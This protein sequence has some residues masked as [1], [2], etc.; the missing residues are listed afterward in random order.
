VAFLLAEIPSQLISKKLGPDRWIPSESILVNSQ[1]L[2]HPDMS[3][4]S[5]NGCLVD[6]RSISSRSLWKGFFLYMQSF[7][8]RARRWLH[9]R[10]SVVVRFPSR[11]GVTMAAM[12]SLT[13]NPQALVFLHQRRATHSPL[14]LLDCFGWDPDID[15]YHG[16][17]PAS[18]AGHTWD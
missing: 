7:D 3:V 1:R 4:S 18:Y 12:K 9:R 14:I 15:I 6:R 8:R 16:F 11:H 5:A 10:P 2:G 17:R 13:I